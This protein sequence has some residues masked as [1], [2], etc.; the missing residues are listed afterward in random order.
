MNVEAIPRFIGGLSYRQ[1]TWL[2]PAAYAVHILEESQ[3]FAEWASTH[4]AAGFTTAQFVQNN[5]II[6]SILLALTALVNVHQRRWTA[7]L[8]FFQLSAGI[9][10]NALL[11]MAATAYVGLYSPGLL[12]AILLYVPVSYTIT[13]R[14]YAEGL[15]P[16]RVAIP[17][18]VLA[19]IAH[20]IFVYTQLFTTDLRL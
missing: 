15:L 18:F 4:F 2:A 6:M 12:S 16:N 5:L 3:H 7:L 9:F 11:H 1:A 8:H 19:G 20:A 14:G 10:H 17:L 13:R